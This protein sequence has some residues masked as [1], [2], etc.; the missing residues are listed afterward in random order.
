MIEVD[1]RV[2]YVEIQSSSGMGINAINSILH[3]Y[4]YVKKVCARWI[5]HNLWITHNLSDHKK[6]S[7]S[8]KIRF[9]NELQQA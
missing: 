7:W 4:L 5:A 9:Q 2:T 8:E 1:R 3:D 6:D